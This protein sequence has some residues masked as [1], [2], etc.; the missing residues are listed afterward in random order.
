M[1]YHALL[2]VFF[3][4]RGNQKNVM[5]NGRID[6]YRCDGAALKNCL[7][8][9]RR[10]VF[11]SFISSVLHIE[12]FYTFFKIHNQKNSLNDFYEN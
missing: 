2:F 5:N 4:Q 11:Y 1:E 7:F 12:N 6:Y 10:H 8:E 9:S 3:F